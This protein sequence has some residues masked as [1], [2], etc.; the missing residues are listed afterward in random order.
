MNSNDPN[1]INNLSS[2]KCFF[3]IK[4]FPYNKYYPQ[5]GDGDEES[6][7]LD[8]KVSDTNSIGN[9]DS[10]EI[11]NIDFCSKCEKVDK[12]LKCEKCDTNDIEVIIQDIDKESDTYGQCICDVS[13]GFYKKPSNNQC[14]CQEQNAYYKSTNLCLPKEELE[15][16]PYYV[17]NDDITDIPIYNDCYLTC[18]KCSK[19]GDEKNNN[20]DEPILMMIK[21]IVIIKMN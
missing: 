10:D 19:A 13:K 12:E 4:F 8:P 17:E 15:N 11:C 3:Q 1:K 18:K 2:N 14:I 7:E 6:D 21:V 20:C 9:E 5:T 16:G